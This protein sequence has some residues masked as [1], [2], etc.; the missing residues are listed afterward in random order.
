MDSGA[1]RTVI[2]GELLTQLAL[3]PVVSS[4][5]IGGVGGLVQSVAINTAIQFRDENGAPITFNGQFAAVTDAETLDMSVLGRDILNLFA[6]ILDR[7]RDV[8]CL[9]RDQHSYAIS[10]P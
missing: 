3:S 7:S 8:V 4:D 10:G 1:D 2:N 9:I 6:V 5:R